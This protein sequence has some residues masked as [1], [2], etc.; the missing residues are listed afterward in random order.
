MAFIWI[1][2]LV[3]HSGSACA[4]GLETHLYFSQ[5]LIW[6]IP[7]IDGDFRRAARRFPQLVMAGACLP[8]LSLVGGAVFRHTHGWQTC[9]RLLDGAGCDEERAVALGYASHLLADVVAHNHFVPAHQA[10]WLDHPLLTHIMAEWAMDSHIRP[11]LFNGAARLL[12]EN[13]QI[14]TACAM[15][16]APCSIEQAQRALKH[17]A[18]ADRLLRRSH[19]P[20]ALYRLFRAIDRRVE[21]HFNYYIGQTAAHFGQI[22]GIING[23]MPVLQAEPEWESDAW[24]IIQNS[25][26]GHLLERMPLPHHLFLHNPNEASAILAPITAK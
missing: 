22:N 1:L 12:D 23:A 2:P 14:L 20:Q 11:H 21:R 5:L 10:L 3:L 19:L 15:K 7:L 4:W 25:S 17:L 24:K 16:L 6:A 26:L 9:E 8:D 18:L 13:R